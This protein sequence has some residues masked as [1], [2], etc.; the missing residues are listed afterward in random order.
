MP[1]CICVWWNIN[2][3]NFHVY[4]CDMEA[5]EDLF[6]EHVIVSCALSVHLHAH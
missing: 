3:G 5:L 2:W 6:K 1:L 4:Q